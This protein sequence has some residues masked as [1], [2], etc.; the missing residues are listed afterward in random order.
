MQPKSQL[1]LRLKNYYWSKGKLLVSFYK[2]II[3]ERLKT[4]NERLNKNRERL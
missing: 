3:N 4:I 1:S 2:K